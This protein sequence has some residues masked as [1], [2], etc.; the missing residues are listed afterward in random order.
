MPPGDGV[1]T[2]LFDE[3]GRL[4]FLFPNG[5]AWSHFR[6]NISGWFRDEPS[7]P[8]LDGEVFVCGQSAVSRIAFTLMLRFLLVWSIGD[9]EGE[10]QVGGEC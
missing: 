6:G 2:F 10:R 5:V 4:K 3:K 1:A 7:R 8:E 9:R